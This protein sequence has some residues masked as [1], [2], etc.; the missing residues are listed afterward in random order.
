MAVARV[1]FDMDDTTS[2]SGEEE[3]VLL[4]IKFL[5]F[6]MLRLMMSK[7]L[8]FFYQY[9]SGSDDRRYVHSGACMYIQ[10]VKWY[11]FPVFNI[12]A[13]PYYDVN[14]I[15]VQVTIVCCLHE[16]RDHIHLIKKWQLQSK[17]YLTRLHVLILILNTDIAHIVG[18]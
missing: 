1:P 17:Q 16:H 5:N 2:S 13:R 10:I 3:L 14:I 11:I 6:V 9:V 4:L 12:Y 15:R 7:S 18:F 8:Y